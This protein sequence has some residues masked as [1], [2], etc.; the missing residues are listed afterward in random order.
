M[1]VGGYFLVAFVVLV[2]VLTIVSQ[3]VGAAALI[4]ISVD[5]VLFAVLLFVIVA[6]FTGIFGDEIA[7]RLV[8]KVM[9]KVPRIGGG[10]G[11]QEHDD[12]ED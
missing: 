9:D 3:R 10:Q 5:G 7:E 6:K 8:D 12:G 11:R 1:I 2:G 4:V